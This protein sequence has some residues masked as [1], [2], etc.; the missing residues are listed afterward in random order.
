MTTGLKIAIAFNLVATLI[1]CAVAYSV[2]GNFAGPPLPVDPP[3]R[4]A[5]VRFEPKS[6]SP[7]VAR[8]ERLIRHSGIPEE[9]RVPDLTPSPWT[10]LSDGTIR[11][12]DTDR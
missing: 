9:Y 7:P 4:R 8:S 5:L 6:E 1:I 2:G 3:A 10:T 11:V 12:R